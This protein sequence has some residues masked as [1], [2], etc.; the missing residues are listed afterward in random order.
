MSEPADTILAAR[1]RLTGVL[2]RGGMGA[3]YEGIDLHTQNTVAIKLILQPDAETTERLMREARAVA[4]VSHP[5]VVKMYDVGVDP[6]GHPFLVMERLHGSGLDVVLREQ[7]RLDPFTAAAVLMPVG[8]ALV[9]AHQFRIVHRDLKPANIFLSTGANGAVLPKVLDFGVAKHVG[10]QSVAMAT[11]TAT[12]AVMGTPA[13]MSPEQV[14][15]GRE[16]DVATDVWAFGILLYEALTGNRPFGG[17]NMMQILLAIVQKDLPP[18]PADIPADLRALIE[19]C[20]QKPAEDR[21]SDMQTVVDRLRPFAGPMP[22]AIDFLPAT[23]PLQPMPNMPPSPAAPSASFLTNFKTQPTQEKRKLPAVVWASLALA[24]VTIAA[25]VATFVR[26]P[27]VIA[28]QIDGPT[29]VVEP[30]PKPSKAEREVVKVAAPPAVEPAP[31]IVPPSPEPPQPKLQPAPPAQAKRPRPRI[32][33]PA[34]AKRTP[35]P[36]PSADKVERKGGLFTDFEP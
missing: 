28:T 32:A 21:F 34:P 20:L 16:I 18:L 9:A 33:K 10:Q 17:I 14:G 26:Q 19:G 4:K 8:E 1:F 2:G 15:G 27:D 35:S 12:G 7:G 5:N 36:K 11:L 6:A 25:L 29:P 31:V 23:E 24:L 13:Y 22:K 3:V 30:A